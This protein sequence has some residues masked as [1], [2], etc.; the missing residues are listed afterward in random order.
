MNGPARCLAACAGGVLLMTMGVAAAVAEGDVVVLDPAKFRA[1][2][3]GKKVELYTLEN[4]HGM[5]VRITNFG[6]KIQQILVPDRYGRLG[7]VVLGY[8]S[9]E[10]V[11]TGLPSAGAFIG[12][13]TNRIA[14]G[15]FIL[16]GKPYQLALNNGPNTLHGGE[17]GSRF[18]VFDAVQRDP[19][20]VEMS[21]TFRDGEENYPGNLATTVTYAVTDDNELTISWTAVTDTRT[22]AAFT[23]HA[24][25]NLAGA[26]TGTILNHVMMINADR[27]TPVNATLIP[28]GELRPVAGTPFEFTKPTA[29]GARIGAENEQ[30]KFGNGYDHNYVLNKATPGELSLAARVTDPVSGRVMEVWSTEPGMQFFSGNNLEGK[31]PRDVGKGAKPYNFRDAFCLEPQRFPD[32]PNQPGFPSPVV[33]PGKPYTGKIIYKFSVAKS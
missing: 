1:E 14:G 7:D 11:R 2:I 18:V 15:R 30:L 19:A 31:P 5:T 25:F 24:F 12:R 20:S 17:K 27:F 33:E 4:R 16:D 3:D 23:G 32:S 26:G 21:Y 8:E 6:A 10:Q 22:I 9:I 28:T 13:Y 29:I